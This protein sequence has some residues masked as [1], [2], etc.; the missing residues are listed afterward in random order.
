MVLKQSLHS[1]IIIISLLLLLSL[2]IALFFIALNKNSKIASEIASKCEV[3]N[4]FADKDKVPIADESITSLTEERNKLKEIYNRFKIALRSPLSEEA[5]K[6]SSDSLQFKERLIQTQKKLSEEAKAHN[7]SLPKSLGFTKYET[8]LPRPFEIPALLGQLKVLEEL[9][10][11]MALSGIDSLY[12]IY[13]IEEKDKELDAQSRKEKVE[14]KPQ[15]DLKEEPPI[16]YDVPVSFKIGC[17]SAELMDFLYKLRLSPFV[18]VIDDLD[19][20]SIQENL[21]ASFSVRA[22]TLN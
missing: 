8:E 10:H 17:T 18:F 7:L 21:K 16:Y 20:E 9:I 12:E 22:I 15:P 3:I 2:S 19:V 11:T 6:E 13:F 5:S 4:K 14:R 1:L